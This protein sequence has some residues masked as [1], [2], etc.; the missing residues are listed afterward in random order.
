[1]TPPAAWHVPA[2][3][4]RQRITMMV[5]RYEVLDAGPGG[6]PG[7]LLALAQQKRMALKE[8]VT[9]Y[10]DDSRTEPL[11]SFTARKRIDLAS[12]YDVADGAGTPLGAFRKDF[13]KS[14]LRSSWHL[15]GPGLEAFGQERSLPVALLR[16]VSENMPLVFHFDF[17]DTGSGA[18]VMSVERRWGLRDTYTVTIPDPRLDLRV[19]ASMA[20]ALDAL[21]GR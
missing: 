8:H 13:G 3:L 1:M 10:S 17:V 2:F 5:N 9:F 7:P 20:V 21:Q 15:S 6:A 19:A 11:F 12:G 4:V 14:L 16:R 18:P